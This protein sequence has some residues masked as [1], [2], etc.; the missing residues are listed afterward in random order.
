MHLLLASARSRT[1]M[2]PLLGLL[3]MLLQL[4]AISAKCSS[5]PPTPCKKIDN[6]SGRVLL[7]TNSLEEGPSVCNFSQ[8]P[9][10]DSHLV[11]CRPRPLKSYEHFWGEPISVGH[12][13][14][15]SVDIAAFTF[16][17][18]DF[19][20][21]WRAMTLQYPANLYISIPNSYAAHCMKPG[22]YR[23]EFGR[24]YC[25]FGMEYADPEFLKEMNWWMNPP[26][27]NSWVFPPLVEWDPR[28]PWDIAPSIPHA[29]PGIGA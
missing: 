5:W 14:G 25:E 28:S 23:T 21:G 11:S 4:T 7:Y 17:D 1:I 13:G 24:P 3:L 8:P 22:G 16:P 12:R 10:V 19:V 18:T 15:R 27:V 20:I 26:D 29:P 2:L 9:F 6:H